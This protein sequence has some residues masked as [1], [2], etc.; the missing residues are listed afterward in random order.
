MR[1][2][3]NNGDAPRFQECDQSLDIHCHACDVDGDDGPRAW[4]DRFQHHFR[5]GI[6]RPTIDINQHRTRS[7]ID[8]DL[9]GGRERPGRHDHLVPWPNTERFECEMQGCRGRVQRDGVAGPHLGRKALFKLLG[10]RARRKPAGV[11][12][13]EDGTLLALG[14]GRPS[15]GK[16]RQRRRIDHG[17]EALA[18]NVGPAE[19]ARYPMCPSGSQALGRVT[20]A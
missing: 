10:P 12:D 20:R 4:R 11:Q 19:S 8:D 16:E 2:V 9:G 18:V 3:L 5:C 6:E 1:R 15:K 13:V 14:N 7:P 17:I